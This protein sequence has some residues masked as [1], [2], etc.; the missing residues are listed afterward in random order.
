[1]WTLAI[2]HPVDSGRTTG[3]QAATDKRDDETNVVKK[4]AAF[5][6]RRL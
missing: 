1:V 3:L 6:I 4:V 2:I 5:Q